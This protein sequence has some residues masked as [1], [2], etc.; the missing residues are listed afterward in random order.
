MGEEGRFPK[1][2]II[3]IIAINSSIFTSTLDSQQKKMSGKF[4]PKVPVQLDPPKSDPI[5]LEALAA[6]NGELNGFLAPISSSAAVYWSCVGLM[7]I[8]QCQH[9]KCYFQSRKT[10]AL[11]LLKLY[12]G[13]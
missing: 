1:I 13:F 6:A 2:N 12:D 7:A 9:A 4:E 5:S 8:S 3:N 10:I 11:S